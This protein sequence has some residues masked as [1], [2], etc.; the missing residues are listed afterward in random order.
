MIEAPGQ[1]LRDIRGLDAIGWWPP[2][3][4]WWLIAILVLILAVGATWILRKRWLASL[5][6][7]IEAMQHLRALR[8]QLHRREPK[9]V[10]GDLSELLRRIAIA[11]GGRRTCAGLVGEAWL[12][13]LNHDDPN[14]FDWKQRGQMLLELPYAPPHI[15]ARVDEIRDLIDAAIRWVTS[16]REDSTHHAITS[17]KARIKLEKQ[18][19]NPHV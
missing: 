15:R 7:R 11:R 13:W 14:G 10:A 3:P 17:L 16:S 8:R 18:A 5:D 6:W 2:A 19:I 9:N 1:Y 12:D 4:G